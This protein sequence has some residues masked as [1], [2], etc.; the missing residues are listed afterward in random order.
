MIRSSGLSTVGGFGARASSRAFE[1]A[2]EE[3]EAGSAAVGCSVRGLF[4]ALLGWLLPFLSARAAALA[5]PAAALS[6]LN[7][8]VP[9]FTRSSF[10]LTNLPSTRTNFDANR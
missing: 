3:A 7:F 1:E 8:A 10:W 6:A 4:G 9:A 2:E 5:C